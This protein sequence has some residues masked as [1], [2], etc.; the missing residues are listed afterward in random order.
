MTNGIIQWCFSCF[1]DID[2]ILNFIFQQENILIIFCFYVYSS[3]VDFLNYILESVDFICKFCFICSV[4]ILY[5]IIFFLKS[6]NLK[7][8]LFLKRGELHLKITDLLEINSS[9]LFHLIEFFVEG[10][11][12]F[13]ERFFVLVVFLL[14][15]ISL[16]RVFLYGD[17]NSLFSIGFN[18]SE[19]FFINFVDSVQL[20]LKLCVLFI[21]VNILLI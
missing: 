2:F 1:S 17:V 21:D 19:F 10:R 9:F 8:S 5:F 12:N 6:G 11:L 3:S 13:L 15:H 20:K 16:S 4:E 14:N 18:F 7:F